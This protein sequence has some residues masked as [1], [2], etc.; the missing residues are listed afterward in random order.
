MISVIIPV[1]NNVEYLERLDAC[2][3][4]QTYTDFEVIHVDDGSTDGS[5]EM[6]EQL[7]AKKAN[8]VVIDKGN[9]G[10]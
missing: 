3:R 2:L 9:G 6:L 10:L 7:T 4:Q 5:A 1:Y 8:Y